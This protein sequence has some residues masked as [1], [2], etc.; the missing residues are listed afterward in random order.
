MTASHADIRDLEDSSIPIDRLGESRIAFVSLPDNVA[1]GNVARRGRVDPDRQQ[2]G[3]AGAGVDQCQAFLGQPKGSDRRVVAGV[4]YGPQFSTGIQVV[5]LHGPRAD[6]EDLPPIADRGNPGCAVGLSQVAFA[7]GQ[8]VRVQ[9]PIVGA[10]IGSP[11]CLAR[12]GIQ[13]RRVLL[14]DAIK[15]QDQAISVQHGRGSRTPVVPAGQIATLPD[16]GAGRGIQPCGAV[17]AEVGKHGPGCQHAAGR[18]IVVVALGATQRFDLLVLEQQLSCKTSPVAWSIPSTN[19]FVPSGVAAVS[20]T[21][22]SSTT[23]EECPW[24]CNSVFQA[25]FRVSLHSMGSPFAWSDCTRPSN[26]GPCRSGHWASTG[27]QSRTARTEAE[28][29]VLIICGRLSV[30]RYQS[31]VWHGLLVSRGGRFCG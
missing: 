1:V 30:R 6:R 9:I 26:V 17:A 12:L 21:L 20:Q 14:V 4:P 22:P 10:A 18:R 11:K 2:L 7:E 19:C 3:R 8:S 28:I 16:D 29:K 31:I 24:S 27:R 25:I 23:G 13:D 5:A 15:R